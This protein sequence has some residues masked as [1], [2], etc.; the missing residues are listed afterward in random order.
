VTLAQQI[1]EPTGDSVDAITSDPLFQVSSVTFEDLQEA[2]ADPTQ[3]DNVIQ[4][5]F[6]RADELT[7]I[8]QR[9]LLKAAL[10]SPSVKAQQ[11]DIEQLERLGWLLEFV[12]DQVVAAG[13]EAEQAFDSGFMTDPTQLSAP[14]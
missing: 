11:Q 2:L 1:D 5:H 10:Q 12:S 9:E 4:R 8:Q 14:A 6:T 3:R 7:E 13:L